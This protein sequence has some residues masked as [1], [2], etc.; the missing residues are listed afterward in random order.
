MKPFCR[1]A[2]RRDGRAERI[3]VL[4][5]ESFVACLR[6][7]LAVI[8]GTE[9]RI[10]AQRGRHAARDVGARG[11]VAAFYRR[12]NEPGNDALAQLIDEQ[13]LLSARCTR[14]ERGQI[15]REV[16]TLNRDRAAEQKQQPQLHRAP[17]E[18]RAKRSNGPVRH[19]AAHGVSLLHRFAAS[20]NCMTERS[21]SACSMTT[22]RSTS[23]VPS[24]EIVRTAFSMRASSGMRVSV[25]SSPCPPT[26]T[27]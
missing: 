8:H 25:Q 15:G 22:V 19:L 18:Q 12:E 1:K 27:L 23:R 11:C 13:P 20:R 5:D 26:A 24:S 7:R 14:Q 17:C 10:A 3:S 21:P 2:L 16:R 9:A 4:K 6:D